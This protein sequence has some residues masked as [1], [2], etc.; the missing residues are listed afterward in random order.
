MTSRSILV[1][2]E[3]T[4]AVIT[5]VSLRFIP[6]LMQHF[7]SSPSSPTW[8]AVSTRSRARWRP[9]SRRRRSSSWTQVRSRSPGR[10]VSGAL[11]RRGVRRDRRGRTAPSRRPG[12]TRRAPRSDVG[13]A[14]RWATPTSP[15]EIAAL[16][17][18]RDGMGLLADGAFGG[19]LSEDIAVPLDSLAAAITR[20]ADIG[21]GWRRAAGATVGDGNLHSTFMFARGRTRRASEPELPRTEPRPGHPARRLR[22]GGARHRPREKAGHLRRQWPSAATELHRGI[23]VDPRGLLNPG[24]KAA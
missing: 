18:W 11:L 2:S 7:R 10:S 17:R 8:T 5:A 12:W 9:G 6:R 4:L 24:K 16:W 19:K 1:G 21:L 15:A 22:V 14:R 13:A 3:G 20:T 23:K